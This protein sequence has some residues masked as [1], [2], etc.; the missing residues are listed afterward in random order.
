VR[1]KHQRVGL[2]AKYPWVTDFHESFNALSRDWN[3]SWK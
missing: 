1:D 3:I 2:V